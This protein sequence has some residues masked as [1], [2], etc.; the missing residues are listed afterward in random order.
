LDNVTLG[1]EPGEVVALLGPNGAGKST[2]L[3]V[4]AGELRP[5]RGV[6][7]LGGRDVAQMTAA[8]LARRRAVVA[9]ASTLAF[10]FTVREVVALG[11][12]V[13]GLSHNGPHIA[14]AVS[15]ALAQVGLT[16]IAN[17][18]FTALSGGE[19]QRA[20]IA[21]ALCQL[22]IAR[23]SRTGGQVLLLDEPTS[24]L[25]IGHQGIVL[26]A[27]RR[28]AGTGVAMVVAMHDLNLAA[29]LA[30]RVAIMSRGRMIAEGTPREA[31]TGAVLS[32]AY[33]C[34]IA[35]DTVSARGGGPLILPLTGGR[36]RA[37]NASGSV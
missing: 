26:E 29:A 15:E 7:T 10:P 1:I 30:D 34:E 3:K 19:R 31:M 11:I 22:A 14:R 37:G 13:P 17:R 18:Y 27:L 9:Q 24:S 4:M 21:R 23:E 16:S 5:A 28:L 35:V 8:D 20:H 12:S 6:V 32:R 36:W 33:E 2:L 25:D